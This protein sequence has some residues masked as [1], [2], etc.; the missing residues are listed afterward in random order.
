VTASRGGDE[1]VDRIGVEAP[2]EPRALDGDP[3]RQRQ[4][5]DERARLKLLEAIIQALG[6]L[7]PPLS[8]SLAISHKESALSPTGLPD[9][10]LEVRRPVDPYDV[11]ADLGPAQ[12]PPRRADRAQP[13]DRLPALGDYDLAPRLLHVIEHA[14]APR[15]EL[16]RVDAPSGS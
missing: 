12:R 9:R 5:R 6:E 3:R 16:A 14:E 4:D 1:L 8:T 11:A 7:K 10:S 13:P 2:A 15:L